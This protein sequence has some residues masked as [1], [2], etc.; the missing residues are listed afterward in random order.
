MICRPRRR[1]VSKEMRGRGV[2]EMDFILSF[3]E[4]FEA[5]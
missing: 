1:S 3:S 5:L 4:D 2:G